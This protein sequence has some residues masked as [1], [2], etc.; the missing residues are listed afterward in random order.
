MISI[1]SLTRNPK[2]V[3]LTQHWF[4]KNCILFATVHLSQEGYGHE[5]PCFDQYNS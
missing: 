2:L 3:H 4:L 5:K 1:A